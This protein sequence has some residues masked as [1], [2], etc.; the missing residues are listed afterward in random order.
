MITNV[1]ASLNMTYS[2][3]PPLDKA[4]GMVE[5]ETGRLT[6]MLATVLAGKADVAAGPFPVHP[7]MNDLLHDMARSSDSFTAFGIISGMKN[8]YVQAPTSFTD[9]FDSLS[10]VLL[11]LCLLAIVGI[12]LGYRLVTGQGGSKTIADT[13]IKWLFN[14]YAV[15]LQEAT[16][17]KPSTFWFERVVT[18]LWL[19]SCMLL[20]NSFAGT[21]RANLIVIQ[22]TFR[23]KSL[24]DV[25]QHPEMT[26]VYPANT[27]AENMINRTA[28]DPVYGNRLREHMRTNSYATTLPGLQEDWLR[29]KL[30]SRK[31][32][33]F[34]EQKYFTSRCIARWCVNSNYLF[35]VSNLFDMF[36][37]VFSSKDL[38]SR[39]NNAI[40]MQILWLQAYAV[41]FMRENELLAGHLGCIAGTAKKSADTTKAAEPNDFFAIWMSLGLGLGGSTFV[42]VVELLYFCLK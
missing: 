40:D 39:L 30:A 15:L 42:F 12:L 33:V 16:S 7:R 4:Y 8:D 21:M 28:Y 32:I 26:V 23:F 9:A 5:E 13:L 37:G 6:G 10:W 36:L 27:P 31:A 11:F 2:I 14:G 24:Y 20:S 34:M 19:V 25:L 29:D 17:E 41:P 18:L 22:P 1:T 3:V 38:P 35:F